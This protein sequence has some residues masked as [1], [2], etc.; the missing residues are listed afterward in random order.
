M[1]I[2]IRDLENLDGDYHINKVEVY[3]YNEYDD[4]NEG[5]VEND[6]KMFRWRRTA[7]EMMRNKNCW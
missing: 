3:L 7:A 4:K 2:Y 5:E 6:N 1:L